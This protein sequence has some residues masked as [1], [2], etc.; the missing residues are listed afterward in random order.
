MD[1]GER[2]GPRM[3]AVHDICVCVVSAT[4]PHTKTEQFTYKTIIDRLCGDEGLRVIGE[5]S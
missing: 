2:T 1:E 3:V 4:K 5:I